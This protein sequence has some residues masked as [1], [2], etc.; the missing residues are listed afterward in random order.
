MTSMIPTPSKKSA[1]IFIGIPASGK[2]SF[3]NRFFKEEY[4]HIN[5]D[6]LHTRGKETTLFTKC[7]LNG[8]SFV[9]DN[10]NTKKS[11]RLRYIT[12][13]KEAGYSII[14]FFFQSI[15]S[16]C[17]VRNNTRSGKAHI[18]DIAI[19]SKSKEL[20]LPCIDEGFDDLFFVKLNDGDFIVEKWRDNS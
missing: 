17:I 14:G 16:D 5:L 12:P 8:D 4:T 7:I 10:T 13:A 9:V 1:V 2:S 3:Y 15:L 19:S 20:E 18:S 6:T 11:D